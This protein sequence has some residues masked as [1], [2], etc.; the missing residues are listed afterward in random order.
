MILK[1]SMSPFCVLH[2]WFIIVLAISNPCICCHARCK[3][4]TSNNEY[5]N[6]F[7]V[8]MFVVVDIP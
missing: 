8:K 3:K 7:H 1:I 6:F 5:D 2:A 4:E